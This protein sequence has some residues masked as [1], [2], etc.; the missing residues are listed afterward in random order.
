[1]KAKP[2]NQKINS[3]YFVNEILIPLEQEFDSACALK[4]R[5]KFYINNDNARV[6]TLQYVKNHLDH[7]C[8]TLLQ[9][10]AYSPDL[11]LWDFDLFGTVK[12]SFKGKSF[13]SEEELLQAIDQFS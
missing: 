11:S 10:P 5:K 12:E 3:E 4:K 8:F 2:Q 7:F 1:M 6:R 9:H 13:D